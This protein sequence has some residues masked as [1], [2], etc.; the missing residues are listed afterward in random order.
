MN[1]CK[2]HE[3]M[4]YKVKHSKQKKYSVLILE[5]V[6]RLIHSTVQN[7]ESDYNVAADSIK[8]SFGLRSF[9]VFQNESEV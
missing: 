5:R 7:S 8:Q 1:P 9:F 4:I 3:A 2:R 6:Y